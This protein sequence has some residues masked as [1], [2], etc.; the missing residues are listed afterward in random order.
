MLKTS[1]YQLDQDDKINSIKRCF[2]EAEQGRIELA[3]LRIND[4]LEDFPDD[5]TVVYHRG[6]LQRDYLGYGLKARDDFERAFHAASPGEEVRSLAAC[7]VAMLARSYEEFDKWSAAALEILPKDRGMNS[8]RS[9]FAKAKS[10]KADYHATLVNFVAV[11]PPE[12]KSNRP[13]E[14]AS[15]LE[16]A[17]TGHNAFL[18]EEEMDVHKHRAQFLRK[19]DRRAVRTREMLSEYLPPE[20]R[21]ALLS[22]VEEMEQA[23]ALEDSD[24]ELWN[25]HAAWFA[26]LRR[27]EE[28][29]RSADIAIDLRPH[30]YAKPWINKTNALLHLNRFDEARECAQEAARQAQAAGV[31][32]DISLAQELVSIRR[33]GKE[34]PDESALNRWVEEFCKA[35]L[36]TSKKEVSQKGWNGEYAELVSGFLK[37]ARL[38]GTNWHPDYLRIIAEMLIYFSP[39]TCHITLVKARAQNEAGYE[40]TLNA[41]LYL[42]VNTSSA[43]QRDATRMLCL[44][45]LGTG[46]I[47]NARNM[48]RQAVL[49]TAAGS[50]EFQKLPEIVRKELAR[51]NLWLPKLV[52]NQEPVDEAEIEHARRTI[53]WRFDSTHKV[54]QTIFHNTDRAIPQKSSVGCII[55]I[56][57][58]L[59][60][61]IAWIL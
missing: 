47:S 60:M 5:A 1:Y 20:E 30:G 45:F 41:L 31:D 53:L 26:L 50:A 18:A 54:D 28:A 4:L 61:F 19:L 51:I 11:M 36:L 15:A 12:E 29:I 34:I 32:A 14:A 42:I 49:E 8:M 2:A 52:A 7:N 23:L 57:V 10:A 6:L 55:L 9:A 43:L 59:A 16:V 13:G 46:S 21:L 3:L 24:A 48:Y 44:M 22:A 56:V 40:N 38:F 37:R 33:T 27:D 17:L 58:A 39:E 25:F 35:A